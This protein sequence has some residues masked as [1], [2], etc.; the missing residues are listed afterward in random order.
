[1]LLLTAVTTL[2]LSS[3]SYAYVLPEDINFD[4]KVDIIDAMILAQAFG[5]QHGDEHWNPNA[6]IVADGQIDIL[7]AIRMARRLG[8]YVPVASFTESAHLVPV[9]TPIEFDPSDSYDFDGTIILYEWD[10][11][12]DGV[13]DFST[14]TSDKVSH[15]YI[16]PGTYNVTLRVTDN[17]ELTNTVTDTKTITPGM[18]IP[19]IPLGTIV[20]SVAMIIG[21]VAYIAVPKWRRKKQ[22]VNS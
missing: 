14:T 7:D 10:F 5:S 12:G 2:F 15:I 18:T 1:M 6:D 11:D 20:A 3:T 13:Y 9:G 21:L 4:G 19:E 8:A 22:Y 16:K 17:D